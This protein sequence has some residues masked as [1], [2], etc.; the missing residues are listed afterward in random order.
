MMACGGVS[1]WWLL[2]KTARRKRRAVL[3]DSVGNFH[4]TSG[5]GD[6][7]GFAALSVLALY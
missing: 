5:R 7:H 2:L 4:P 3:V 1:G 6:A